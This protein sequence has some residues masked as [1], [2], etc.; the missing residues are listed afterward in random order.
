MSD[1]L[2]PICAWVLAALTLAALVTG[3]GVTDPPPAQQTRSPL[4]ALVEPDGDL[5]AL[6]GVKVPRLARDSAERRARR[7]TVRVRNIG[8]GGLAT[9]SGWALSRTLLVTNRHVLAGADSLELNTWDGHDLRV[10]TANVGRLGDLGIV[11]VSGRLPQVGTLGGAVGSGERVT[12]VGYPLGGELR[13][14]S[15]AV[16]DL[17]GGAKFGIPGRVIRLTAP[18]QPGNSG[19]PLLDHSGKIVGVVFAKEIAT[20]LTLAIPIATLKT[21]VRTQDLQPVPGCGL[22]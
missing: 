7:L 6:S 17:V 4:P 11:R 15:G 8:C 14:T 21:L 22:E 18:V 13:L 16:V 12:A 1:R 2:R 10:T 20:G 5:E 9:G 3:C 19:G